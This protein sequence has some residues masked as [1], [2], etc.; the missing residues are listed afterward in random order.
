MSP[1]SGQFHLITIHHPIVCHL[2]N[3]SWRTVAAVAVAGGLW[4]FDD[5]HPCGGSEGRG[6]DPPL[7]SDGSDPPPEERE[8]PAK[9]VVGG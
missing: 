6:S 7:G 2:A 4:P 5:E 9:W 3:M 8:R 1:S